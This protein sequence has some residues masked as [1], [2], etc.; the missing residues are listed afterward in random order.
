MTE[1]KRYDVYWEGDLQSEFSTLQEAKDY[2]K[3]DIKGMAEC[4]GKT[5]KQIKELFNWTI[6]EVLYEL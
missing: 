4:Y 2:I 5:Q 3:R 1:K 6:E